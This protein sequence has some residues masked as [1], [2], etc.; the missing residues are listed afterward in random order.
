MAFN[1]VTPVLFFIGI[2]KAGKKIRS[3]FVKV[4]LFKVVVADI[5][6]EFKR[7]ELCY[8]FLDGILFF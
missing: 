2:E 5:L 6:D 7:V 1:I 3:F 8:Y 4:T